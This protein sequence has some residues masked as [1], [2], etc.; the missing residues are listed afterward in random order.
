[1]ASTMKLS[2]SRTTKAFRSLQEESPIQLH[3]ASLSLNILF[4][5]FPLLLMIVS[6]LSWIGSNPEHDTLLL[7]NLYQLLPNEAYLFVSETLERLLSSQSVTV[8]SVGTL[9]LIWSA[10]RTM[11]TMTHSLNRIYR[12]ESKRA[13]VERVSIAMGFTLILGVIFILASNILIWGAQLVT[14]LQNA[15]A[16]PSILLFFLSHLTWPFFTLLLITLLTCTYR[17]LPS[18]DIET[19]LFDHLPGAVLAT[20]IWIF[21]ALFFNLY[22][23]FTTQF[24]VYGAIGAFIILILYIQVVSYAFLAGAYMNST[25][26]TLRYHG[27]FRQTWKMLRTGISSIS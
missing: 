2:P 23:G 6:L 15:F 16:I 20:S 18:H 7:N 5:L 10:S 27:F 19:S 25:W 8:F 12:N 11:R 26:E 4:G 1:M 17:F 24:E 3:A 13:W 14:S 22:L 21:G 9:L